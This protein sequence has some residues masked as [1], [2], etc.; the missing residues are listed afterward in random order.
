MTLRGSYISGNLACQNLGDCSL[1]EDSVQLN[2]LKESQDLR[3]QKES[4]VDK[5]IKKISA[6]L[7][8]SVLMS[9]II[10]V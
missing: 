6:I 1:F 8:L 4:P 10:L 7:A 2:M 9:L 3:N 5:F